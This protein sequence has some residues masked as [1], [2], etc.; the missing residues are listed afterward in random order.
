[1]RLKPIPE[2][3]DSLE[4]VRECQE[5]LPLVPGSEDD[6]CARL[7]DRVGVEARD[8]AR[9]WLTFLRA[10]DLATEHDSGYTRTRS[11]PDREAL[12]AAFEDGV[13]AAREVLTALRDS[14]E[15]LDAAATFEHVEDV[16]PQWERDKQPDRWRD[17]WRERVRRLLEWAALLGLAERAG[18]GYVAAD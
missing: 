3:P 1:V 4:G 2:P 14:E 8:D 10:V 6:C 18:D 17:E 5:A 13:F 11:E 16:V 12:A 15:P 7:M 9:T